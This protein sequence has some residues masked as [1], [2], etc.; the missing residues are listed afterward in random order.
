MLNRISWTILT[1]FVIVLF[2]AFHFTVSCRPPVNKEIK[3]PVLEAS[4]TA[5]MKEYGVV[6]CS[7]TVIKNNQNIYNFNYGTA[8]IKNNEPMSNTHSIRL[9]SLSKLFTSIILL[10]V[11]ERYPST[12]INEPISKLLEIPFI[13]P[14]FKDNKITLKELVSHT[15]SFSPS[16]T[17]DEFI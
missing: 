12:N 3:D 10:N 8:D 15:S 9:A 1:L 14:N 2:V 7:L 5:I 6:G 16:A 4:L 13:N 11:L 17:A